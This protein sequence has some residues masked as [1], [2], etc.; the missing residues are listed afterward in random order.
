MAPETIRGRPAAPPVD[1][2]ALGAVGCY[3]LTGRPIFD[4]GSALEFVSCHLTQAPVPPSQRGISVPPDLEET[5]LACLR[6]DPGERVG[7]AAELRRRLLQCADAG[8]WTPDDAA[9]WWR[10]WHSSKAAASASPS[11]QGVA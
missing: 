4:V 6:K 3:L 9:A 7:S 1:I 5:L 8:R 2:Y 11:A 10:D